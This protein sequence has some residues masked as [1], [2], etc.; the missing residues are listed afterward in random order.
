M[1]PGGNERTH[2]LLREF[3][4]AARLTQRQLAEAAG[5]S[6]G[7]VRDLEQGRTAS[8]QARSADAI[9]GALGLSGRRSW[10]FAVAM[11]GKTAPRHAAATVGTVS[12]GEPFGLRL[13][14]LGPLTAWRHGTLVQLGPPSQRAVLALLAVSPDELLHRETIIDALW[15]DNPPDAALNQVQRYAS[16]LR[17]VLDP[18]RSPRDPGGLI[19][20]TGTGYRLRITAAQLDLLAFRDLTNRAQAAR[21]AGD[22]DAACDLYEEAMGLWRGDPLSDVDVLRRHPAVL[23]LRRQLAAGAVAH[24]ETASS[25]GWYERALP[26]LQRLTWQEPLH[27]QAHALLMIAL[28]ATGQQ[29]DALRVFEDLRR[30]LS[31]QFGVLPCAQLVE[32]RQ[33]VLSGGLP[34]C[35]LPS[36]LRQ[37]PADNATATGARGADYNAPFGQPRG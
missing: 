14:V 23:G 3:R 36:Q 8:L 10:E 2:A 16:R 37:N 26:Y 1:E 29:A 9:I 22:A 35:Q 31:A 6:I 33:R 28:A 19:V 18:G 24:A 13:S 27:E 12:V 4:R 5:V 17:R 20:S 21:A 15:D 7:V 25:A 30:R 32:A 34:F 11:R